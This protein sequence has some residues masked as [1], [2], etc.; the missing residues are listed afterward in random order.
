MATPVEKS[1]ATLERGGDFDILVASE[2]G[3]AILT[4]LSN[5]R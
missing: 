2:K 3:V 1:A 5:N 4:P